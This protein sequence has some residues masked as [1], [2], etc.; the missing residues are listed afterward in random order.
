[1]SRSQS[2][3]RVI[4]ANCV[5]AQVAASASCTRASTRQRARRSRSS[6]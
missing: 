5:S 6:M 4:R 2:S 1:V 3:H